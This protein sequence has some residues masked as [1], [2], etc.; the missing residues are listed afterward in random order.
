[1]NGVLRHP[2]SMAKIDFLIMA[3][4][5]C[6]QMLCGTFFQ[7]EAIASHFLHIFSNLETLIRS[8]SPGGAG[9]PNP[10]TQ[11]IYFLY[12]FIMLS[13]ILLCAGGGT[14]L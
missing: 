2:T 5:I 11:L 14:G 12:S 6:Q 10:P 8:I 7:L 4:V 9:G 13:K 1:M 3:T